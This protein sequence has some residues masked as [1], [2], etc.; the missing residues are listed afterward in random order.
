MSSSAKGTETLEDLCGVFALVKID[1]QE[2]VV[3]E[4]VQRRG[5]ARSQEDGDI[6][7]LDEGHGRLL[8][9]D[10][11]WWQHLV[12][13][14]GWRGSLGLVTMVIKEDRNGLTCT[15]QRHP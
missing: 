12:D 6:F 11:G 2:N 10:A 14:P 8:E 15:E 1:G 4:Q 5:F 3:L 9:L 7:H 13:E